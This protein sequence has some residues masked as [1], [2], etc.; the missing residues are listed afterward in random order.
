MS[1]IINTNIA[2]LTAQRNLGLNNSQLQHSLERLSSGLRVNRSADDAA[3][4]SIANS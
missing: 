1:L 3:G 2:S 4:L